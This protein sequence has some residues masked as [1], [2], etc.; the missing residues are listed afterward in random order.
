MRPVLLGLKITLIRKPFPP[1]RGLN[2]VTGAVHVKILSGRV[3]G[4]RGHR[5]AVNRG[6][7]SALTALIARANVRGETTS[8]VRPVV[9]LPGK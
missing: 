7:E 2:S 8:M 5:S 3:V 1:L 4:R 6:S 9:H